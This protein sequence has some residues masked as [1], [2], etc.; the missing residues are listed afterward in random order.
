MKAMKYFEGIFQCCKRMTL[1]Q[2]L[3]ACCSSVDKLKVERKREE[4][5]MKYRS[6]GAI[7]IVEPC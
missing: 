5:G 1:W 6:C 7:N 3:L 4:L 2:Q